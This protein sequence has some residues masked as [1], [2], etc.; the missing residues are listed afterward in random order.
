MEPPYRIQLE[1]NAILVIYAPRKIPVS[2]RSKVRKEL[3]EM[4]ADGVTERG[5]RRT[6]RVG[7][8][9]GG[10]RKSR[11]FTTIVP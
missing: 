9:I 11:W 8:F 3:D 4:E 7:K 2:L 10:C 6:N 5:S 1:E